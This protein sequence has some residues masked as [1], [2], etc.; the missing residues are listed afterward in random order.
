MALSPMSWAAAIWSRMSA[1]RGETSSAGPR[2]RSRRILAE[3]K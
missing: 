3:A 1:S 2:P